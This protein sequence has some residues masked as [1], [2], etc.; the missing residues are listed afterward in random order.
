MRGT[1]GKAE[2]CV[3]LR[4]QTNGLGYM[5]G[6]WQKFIP[7]G[8][9]EWIRNYGIHDEKHGLWKGF[10]A[11]GQLHYERYYSRDKPFGLCRFYFDNGQP[12]HQ[13]VFDQAGVKEGEWVQYARD[14][15]VL[16]HILYENGKKT[17]V[18]Q[19]PTGPADYKIKPKTGASLDDFL[20]NAAFASEQEERDY[21]NWLNSVGL[22]PTI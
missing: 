13:G 9:T 21:K 8:K 18:M 5:A 1:A 22:T 19:D 7:D 16:W 14:G 3:L 6:E 15:R 12:E 4:G 10:H 20:K 2:G 11:N 17:N